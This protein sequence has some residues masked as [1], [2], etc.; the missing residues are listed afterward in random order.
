M[1]CY[2]TGYTLKYKLFI[3][4][5]LSALCMQLTGC[6]DK[7]TDFTSSASPEL[8][9]IDPDSGHFDTK[10]TISGKN[11]S[12]NI[13]DNIVRFNNRKAEI[14]ESSNNKLV[15]KVPRRAGTGPVEVTVKGKTAKGPVFKFFLTVTTETWAGD[16]KGHRDAKGLQARFNNPWGLAIKDRGG[17]LVGD[18]DNSAIR[19]IDREQHVTTLAGGEHSGFQD[20]KGQEALFSEPMGIA[21]ALDG[22]LFVADAFNHTIRS[23]TL[24]GV[25][26]TFAGTGK[27]G[28]TEGDRRQAQFFAPSDIAV[29]SNLT[30]YITDTYNFAI[31]KITPNGTVETLAGSGEQGHRDG[32][33]LSAAFKL[34]LSIALGPDESL[35]YV[36]DFFGHR[37]RQIDIA[38]GSVST[39]AGS[40]KAG[41]IDGSLEEARF[42]KPAGIAVGSE[43]AIYIADSGN[44]AIRMIKNGTVTT[45]AGN[46]TPGY[47]D[48]KGAEARFNNPYHLTLSQTGLFLYVSDW[49]NHRIRRLKLQ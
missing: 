24:R 22:T 46:G 25:V 17:L 45:L 23:V 29:S 3:L 36:A 14:I 6:K 2:L 37:I 5:L 34:P 49:D 10:V 40:G 20:G 28:Y 48:G 26:N 13:Q 47:K 27:A 38:T 9:D 44:H 11:F 12:E 18:S 30:L 42:N 16:I 35:L 7:S 31:R 43:G 33:A 4:I 39:L 41:F 32:R 15:A 19:E 1:M 8:S 21:F